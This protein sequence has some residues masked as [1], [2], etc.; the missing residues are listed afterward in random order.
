MNI[1]QIQSFVALAETGSFTEAAEQLYLSQSA[2]SHALAALERELGVT[3]IERN[4]KGV[5]ALSEAGERILPHARAF[6]SQV[7]AIEQEAK[8][9]QG[10]YSGKL[11]LGSIHSFVAPDLLAPLLSHFQGRYP[12][13]EVT[14]FEGAIHE[15]GEWME[16]NL[17]DLSFM[18]LPAPDYTTR[19]IFRDELFVVLPQEHPLQECDTLRLDDLLDHGLVVERGHCTLRLMEQ[20]GIISHAKKPKIR[21]KA[22]DSATILAMVREG[23][24]F[25]FMPKSMLPKQTDGLIVRA[26]EPR[27]PL[28]IGLGVKSWQQAS[29]NARLFIE[30][31]QQWAN[32]TS[33]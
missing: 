12:E 10:H 29:P 20:L 18:I 19:P 9:A 1:S 31:A 7:S 15:I 2:I 30:A 3:L 27:F 16:S 13:V 6:L 5:I 23:L 22:H 21:Y 4:R 17:I 14:L 33:A 32:Q 8:A 11:R 28:Q 26:L 24:G 25:T